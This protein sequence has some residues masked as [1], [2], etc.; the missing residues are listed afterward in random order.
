MNKTPSFE[1]LF[2]ECVL[3]RKRLKVEDE[4][5]VDVH[6]DDDVS[7]DPPELRVVRKNR[8]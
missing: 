2:M 4:S 7:G 1:G 6:Q 8:P 3:C 5:F